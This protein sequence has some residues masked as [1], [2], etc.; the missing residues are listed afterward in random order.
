MSLITLKTEPDFDT[1]RRQFAVLGRSIAKAETLAISTATRQTGSEARRIVRDVTGLK[2]KQIR[3]RVFASVRYSQ[4]RVWVGLSPWPAGYLSPLTPRD[5]SPEQQ[6]D[7]PGSY[8][9]EFFFKGAFVARMESGHLGIFRRRY[10]GEKWHPTMGSYAG[11]TLKR[12]PRKGSPILREK[13]AEEKVVFEAFGESVAGVR[14]R[15]EVFAEGV[16]KRE[17]IRQMERQ[18]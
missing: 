16:L 1:V 7:L 6:A 14:S 4:G 5:M 12:G 10:S 11:R 2:L 13:L 15:L 8:A 18:A 3:R 17:F 9:R